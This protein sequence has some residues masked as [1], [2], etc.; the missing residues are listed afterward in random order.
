MAAP[1][2][3]GSHSVLNTQAIQVRGRHQHP[4]EMHP[5]SPAFW[6]VPSRR[7]LG[8]AV[9]KPNG[10]LPKSP[11]RVVIKRLERG[12]LHSTQNCLFTQARAPD[13]SSDWLETQ[14]DS[15]TESANPSAKSC[16][17]HSPPPISEPPRMQWSNRP[18]RPPSL[19]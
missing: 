4:K 16:E 7:P 3:L 10:D 2:S 1:N 5:R 19:P 9:P 15:G 13:V 6:E 18:Q 14:E 17:R 8:C 12:N 11:R